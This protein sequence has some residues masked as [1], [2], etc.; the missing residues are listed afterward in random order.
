MTHLHKVIYFSLVTLVLNA[1]FAHSESKISIKEALDLAFEQLPEGKEI[2][3]IE[4]Q[5]DRDDHQWYFAEYGEK[6]VPYETKE[7]NADGEYIPCTKFRKVTVGIKIEMNKE[8]QIDQISA[9]GM[10]RR[11]VILP[12][13]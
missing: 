10:P 5:S 3:S 6:I 8:V 9:T 11:R 7:M 4:L 1:G 2:T 12:Q 13:K